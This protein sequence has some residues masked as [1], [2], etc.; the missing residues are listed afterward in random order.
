MAIV[1][2]GLSLIAWRRSAAIAATATMPLVMLLLVWSGPAIWRHLG[3]GA[4]RLVSRLRLSPGLGTTL[5]LALIPVALITLVSLFK[6]IETSRGLVTFTPFMICALAAGAVAIAGTRT[7]AG[8]VAVI[9][10]TLHAGSVRYY[11]AVPSPNDYRGIAR[12]LTA[13]LQAG[14]LIFVRFQDWVTTPLFYHLPGEGSRL[15][16]ERFDDALRQH[17]GAR[18]WVPLFSEQQPTEAMTAALA[19]YTRQRELTAFRA[20]AVLYVR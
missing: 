9:L 6:P 5:I 3:P 1:V 16:A 19:G 15:V 2:L 18:V 10:L 8:M 12:A 13:E 4:E 7:L 20:R 14:D 17:P 11:R